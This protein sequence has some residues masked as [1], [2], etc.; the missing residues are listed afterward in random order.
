M[1]KAYPMEA[2]ILFPYQKI[3]FMSI[4]LIDDKV[5]VSMHT[6]QQRLMQVSDDASLVIEGL[7]VADDSSTVKMHNCD[8]ACNFLSLIQMFHSSTRYS[9]KREI[10][11]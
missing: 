5:I 6:L 8:R 4:P 3:S 7:E 1:S 10:F 2:I 9:F 11:L